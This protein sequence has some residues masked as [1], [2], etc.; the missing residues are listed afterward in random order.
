ML[1]SIR[2]NV[3]GTMAKI[4][5]G[6]IIVPF[7]FFG[8]D[9][10]FSGGGA[11][12]AA[13]VN[14]AEITESE[15]N[16]AIDM[17]K[18]RIQQQLGESFDPAM[19]EDNM[20]KSSVLDSLVQRQL[21]K[22]EAT[23]LALLVPDQVVDQIIVSDEAFHE[24]GKFSAQRYENLIRSNGLLPSDHRNQ[25]R[26][27]LQLQQL[28]SGFTEGAFATEKEL[29]MVARLTQERRDVRFLTVP[30]AKDLSSIA[31]SDAERQ[32]YYAEHKKEF[33][34]DEQV[35]LEFVELRLQ[36]LY[37][38][39]S[40]ADIKATYEREKAAF[41]AAEERELAHILLE[42]NDQR[43]EKQARQQ[44]KEIGEQLQ[45][46]ADF[47]ELAKKYTE[48]VGTAEFGGNLGYVKSGELPEKFE[49]AANVLT[50]GA[51]SEPIVT[52]AGVHL[53]KLLDVKKDEPPEYASSKTRIA[54]DLQKTGAKPQ[55]V[56]NLE[57]LAD[58]VFG[59]DDLTAA[60]AELDLT[61]QQTEFFNRN[62]G[63]SIA[64]K[65]QVL[66]LA[67]DEEFI[68]ERQNS[69][70]LELDEDHAVVVRVKNHK[71][72]E[73]LELASVQDSVDK[74]IRRNKANDAAAAQARALLQKVQE[75]QN[76]KDLAATHK[77]EWE[78]EAGLQRN[79][80]KL[81]P[82]ILGK[83]FDATQFDDG[84]ALELLSLSSGDQVV[85][86][87]S[88]VKPGSAA[89]LNSNERSSIKRALAQGR[90]NREVQAYFD[91]L[92]D[93]ADIKMF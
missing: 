23:Q 79:S 85:M 43:T 68:D 59:A 57:L 60:A 1:Q 58:S 49:Q 27:Q 50:V 80:V 32:A 28:V 65:P 4:I 29:E 38:D 56:E 87:V 72:A 74:S 64:A 18:R 70:V 5:V 41:E 22:E 91:R 67:F 46:G 54:E 30:V 73:Q 42:V 16:I 48:D 36:D 8:V 55:F 47:A 3:Q 63:K 24:N 44:L 76:I 82:E 35:Q 51:I 86:Q 7:V 33:K 89:S 15:L 71:P 13:E 39:V 11:K 78:L 6:I 25:I 93:S 9:A 12:N 31:V 40:D 81:D 66:R 92:K 14:G 37:E 53:I 2:N 69:E 17:Q 83:A 26:T 75:G 88:N 90:G 21:L 19:L 34:S 10:L 52:E 61:V 77:L 20:I 84:T 45:K 62:G